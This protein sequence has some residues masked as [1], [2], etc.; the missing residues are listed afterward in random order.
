[1]KSKLFRAFAVAFAVTVASVVASTQADSS[2]GVARV[3][4][5]HG[6][7]ST[8]RGDSGDWAAAALNQPIVSGDKISTGD[9]SRAE[10]QLDYANILR[11]SDRTQASIANLTRT[12]V[13]IQISQGLVDY[14]V[15]KDT[16]ADVQLDMPNVSV[17]PYQKD[18]I[19][20]IEV[21]SDEETRII[22][23]KGEAEVSTPQG[24][25]RLGKGQVINVRGTGSDTQYRIAEAPSKDGWDSWN[26]ERDGL[27]RNA[28]AW[29]NTNRYYVGSEDL[30]SYGRWVDVP[31]YG[32][33]WSPYVAAGWAPY[34]TGRW[35]W[36]PYWGW[37]WVSYEPWGWAPYHY[38]RWFLYDSA[39]VW[40][41]G[42]VYTHRYYRP[43]WAPAYVSFFGFGHGGFGFGFGFGS[44]G[45]L[46]IGPCDRFYPWY[47]HYRS[48]F[49]VVNVTNINVTNINIHNNRRFDG[50][51]PL[52]H[53]DRF[54][55]LRLVNSDGRIRN[56]LSTVPSEHFGTGRAQIRAVNHDEFREGGVMRGNLPVVPGRESLSVTGRAA[57]PSTLPREGRREHFF[58]TKPAPAPRSFDREVAEVHQ[59]IQRD[60]NSRAT[61]TVAE[62][63]SPNN[64]RTEN[65]ERNGGRNFGNRPNADRMPNEGRRPEGS[66]P[67]AA[68][69]TRGAR[70]SP[71]NNGWRRF[72]SEVTEDQPRNRATGEGRSA[73]PEAR[74][75]QPRGEQPRAEQPRGNQG[76]EQPRNVTPR[77]ADDNWR[78]FSDSGSR[79]EPSNSG[80]QM[81]GSEPRQTTGGENRPARVEDRQTEPREQAPNRNSDWRNFPSQTRSSENGRQ[82]N[83]GDR[84][85]RSPSGGNDRRVDSSPRENRGPD[86]DS[87]R[88]S[89][90][91]LDLNRPIVTP[92]ES[93]HPD[94]GS[95]PR[96][97]GGGGGGRSEPSRG[98]GD[99]GGSR[100]GQSHPSS[101]GDRRH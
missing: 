25:S 42:P 58:S 56:G 47:G 7:V 43:I 5:I 61:R 22:V 30:D 73:G 76:N 37:T 11:L 26:S 4:L 8:Q 50:F 21:L 64:A 65:A 100:G 2:A 53:G 91:P 83:M 96:S 44:V 46:P 20:R 3:S 72:G 84:S 60:G 78:R 16:E 13:Q 34:R 6:E 95:S 17:H 70:T 29:S 93:P 99:R 41:P 33:V 39:W 14:T 79:G 36:Q 24:R 89:R 55:N 101:G 31:D 92:R 35:V 62:P 82:D 94:R 66:T 63:G 71:A 57:N 80:P 38:G 10:V 48:H 85:S 19:Y 15:F 59:A 98:G 75:E 77:K 97:G 86:R 1:M 12:Q 87:M 68:T 52:H 69:E 28:R 45:W 67:S 88:G 51:A 9:G 54:S 32:Q 81:N 23:R 40:W 18:G 74:G 90:P 27:I 49:N